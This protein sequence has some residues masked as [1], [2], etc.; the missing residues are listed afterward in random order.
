MRTSLTIAVTVTGLVMVLLPTSGSAGTLAAGLAMADAGG[1]ED[2]GGGPDPSG[3]AGWR[4]TL[5]RAAEASRTHGFR[6]R[7]AIVAFD[8]GGPSLAEVEVVQDASGDLQVG[9]AESWAVGRVDQQSFYWESDAGTLLQLEAMDRPSFD[10]D[11]LSVK[12]AP[13]LT[14]ETSLL[15]GPAQAVTIRERSSGVD[16][17][18]LYVDSATGLVVRRET[19]GMD[20]RPRRLVAFTDLVVADTSVEAP[21][22][23][24]VADMGPRRLVTPDGM[25]ILDDVGWV[26]A[27]D[28]PGGFRLH[29]G[30]AV[31]RRGDASLHLV[32]GDGLY[33]LSV[34]EQFGALDT[35]ALD[36]AVVADLPGGH[37][38][39]WPGSEPE[40]MVWTAQDLTFTAIS[41]A[42]ADQVM[43][44]ISGL[45]H[46]PPGSLGHRLLRGLARLGSW[47]WP[48]G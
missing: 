18:T 29:D 13:R 44:A 1:G 33:T 37:V 30:Y 9:R 2:P 24:A 17:E 8:D 48:F 46:D 27:Q 39:R 19:Y 5:T 47:L 43:E 22:A 11:A 28:L 45:P 31:D 34:Y 6:G 26:V 36:G 42:P 32:Y 23:K 3:E 38:Y 20:G 35:D 21:R 7:L 12:Y 10:L 14:G 4:Q 25:R 15:T 16:R 41:D 40:R